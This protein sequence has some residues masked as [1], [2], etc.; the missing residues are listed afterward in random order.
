MSCQPEAR[1]ASHTVGLTW[2][3]GAWN[4]GA[5]VVLTYLPQGGMPSAGTGFGALDCSLD[6]VLLESAR[7]RPWY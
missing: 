3:A 6:V 5:L 4:E 2:G 1:Y 7:Q